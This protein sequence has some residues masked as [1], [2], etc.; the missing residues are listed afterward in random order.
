M[1]LRGRFQN[2]IVAMRTI[3]VA[4]AGQPFFPLAVNKSIFNGIQAAS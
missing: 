1:Q 3:Y 4:K 2:K